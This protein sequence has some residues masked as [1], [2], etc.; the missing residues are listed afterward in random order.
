MAVAQRS[1]KGTGEGARDNIEQGL[2]HCIQRYNTSLQSRDRDYS[3]APDADPRSASAGI[4]ARKG[5]LD[6]NTEGFYY[7]L[8]DDTMSIMRQVYQLGR[9]NRA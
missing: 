4:Y 6:L 2:A 8:R 7:G 5:N 1:I 9:D 3:D